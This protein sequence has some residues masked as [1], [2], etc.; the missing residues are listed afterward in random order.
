MDANVIW[1]EKRRGTCTVPGGR[2][3]LGQGH[4]FR[5]W[6]LWTGRKGVEEEK[7]LMCTGGAHPCGRAT[8]GRAPAWRAAGCVFC[9]GVAC[10]LVFFS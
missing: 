9:G 6:T 1:Q 5:P 7:R 8:G 3:C 4:P 10:A 2:D